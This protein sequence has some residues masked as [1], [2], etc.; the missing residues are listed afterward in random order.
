M[1]LIVVIAI[2]SVLAGIAVPLYMNYQRKAKVSSYALPIVKACAY[3]AAGHCQEIDIS[4]NTHIN[5]STLI[6]CQNTLV[7]VGSLTVNIAGSVVCQPDGYVNSG[8]VSG[9]LSG[10]SDYSAI[11]ILK[12][13][14][15]ECIVK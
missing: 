2:I 8:T 14:G 3:E 5:V 9:V 13:K 7:P 11:C 6:N 12:N 15:V 10:I 4:A 1:E